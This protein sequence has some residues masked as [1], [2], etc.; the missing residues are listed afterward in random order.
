ME[1]LNSCEFLEGLSCYQPFED[2]TCHLTTFRR[3]NW[4]I[5]YGYT[6]LLPKVTLWVIAL[7]WD[8]FWFPVR[9]KKKKHYKTMPTKRN[10]INAYL[11]QRQVKYN[12][13]EPRKL[14]MFGATSNEFAGTCQDICRNFSAAPQKCAAVSR[15]TF[16]LDPIG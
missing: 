3:P 11:E 8:R 6:Y 10:R 4:P 2:I 1:N 16:F 15:I 9:F 14:A 7:G 5:S 12:H 13:R